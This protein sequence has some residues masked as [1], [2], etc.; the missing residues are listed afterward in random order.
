[1]STLAKI[2]S[3]VIADGI[4]GDVDRKQSVEHKQT[5]FKIQID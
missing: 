2:Y 4:E 5:N 1:M 3:K